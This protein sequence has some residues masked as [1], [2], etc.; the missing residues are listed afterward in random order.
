MQNVK[1]KIK[2]KAA[3]TSHSTAKQAAI[4]AKNAK[5]KNLILTHFSARYKDEIGHLEEAQQIQNK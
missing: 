5:V 2:E 3:E 4:L 1:C